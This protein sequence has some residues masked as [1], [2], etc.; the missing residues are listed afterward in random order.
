VEADKKK[1][2]KNK[3]KAKGGLKM[4]D[5]V[6]KLIPCLFPLVIEHILISKGYNPD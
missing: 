6:F 2:K 3:D 5:V 1:K 4:K